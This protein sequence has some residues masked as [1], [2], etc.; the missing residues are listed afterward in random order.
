MK[1]VCI[2]SFSGAYSVRMRDNTDQKN[3]KYRHFS[4][5]VP[6][7]ILSLGGKVAGAGDVTVGGAQIDYFVRSRTA[8]KQT[9]LLFVEYNSLVEQVKNKVA[10]I[11][12]LLEDF[13]EMETDFSGWVLFWRKLIFGS[14]QA[15]KGIVW[16][17]VK[18][19]LSIVSYTDDA[20]RIGAA[21]GATLFK[22]LGNVGKGIHIAG[23]ILGTILV[24]FDIYTLVISSIDEHNR[25]PHQV[26]ETI[27]EQAKELAEKCPPKDEIDKTKVTKLD[28]KKQ[29]IDVTKFILVFQRF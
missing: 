8:R 24:P 14:T 15:G 5:N 19:S 3:S 17:V 7:I 28:Y 13:G 29:V 16:D 11:N 6:F 26:S 23:G 2:R 9:K 1:S 20:A 27:R 21:T 22:T 12:R 18:Y 10:T 4:R 25:N